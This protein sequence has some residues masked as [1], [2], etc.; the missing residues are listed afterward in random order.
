[1]DRT[2]FITNDGSTTIVISSTKQYF[3]SIHGAIQ[4]SM[5]VFIEGGLL[6]LLR[7]GHQVNIFELGFGTGLNALLTLINTQQYPQPIH[8]TAVEAFPLENSLVEEL[9]YCE[10]LK[11]ADMKRAFLQMHESSW[12]EEV[13]LSPLF[14]LKKIK[15]SLL[16]YS[17]S[18]LFN[19]IYFDAFAP[20]EQPE[21]WT[22]EVFKRMFNMLVPGGILVTYSAKGSVRRS[23]QAVGFKVEKLP[24][25]TGKREMLRAIKGNIA[26]MKQG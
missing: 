25:A 1:M 16:E 23:M 14:T 15:S 4:E 26:R 20:D 6:P 10:I 2:T 11:R 13:I 3:H 5:H 18:E 8:Y 9:N 19:L 12:N 17:T 7:S 22:I 21:L 24:G